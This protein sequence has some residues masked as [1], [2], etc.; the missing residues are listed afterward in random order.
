MGRTHEL[1]VPRKGVNR[2]PLRDSVGRMLLAAASFG[3]TVV[4]VL[5]AS[6]GSGGGAS[7][8]AAKLLQVHR[9]KQMT[10]HYT[11]DGVIHYYKLEAPP[12]SAYFQ[13]GSDGAGEYRSAST[14]GLGFAGGGDPYKY[15]RTGHYAKIL[16][17]ED[18]LQREGQNGT[19]SFMKQVGMQEL[20]ARSIKSRDESLLKLLSAEV[21]KSILG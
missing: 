5:L 14:S 11:E 9:L 7:S 15:I 10:G 17:D 4:V 1:V 21:P 18:R 2:L 3:L 13:P 16:A 12:P 6:S 19:A 8:A 20:A